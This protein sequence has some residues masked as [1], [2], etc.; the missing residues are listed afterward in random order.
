MRDP[1]NL[2]K[3]YY[4]LR[5]NLYSQPLLHSVINCIVIV[6]KIF[7]FDI[8]FGLATGLLIYVIS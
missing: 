3:Y 5:S 1:N 2:R 6:I 4:T 7:K 8:M